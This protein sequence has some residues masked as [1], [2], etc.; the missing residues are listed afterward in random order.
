MEALAILSEYLEMHP[1]TNDADTI[2]ELIRPNSFSKQII[3]LHM[4]RISERYTKADLEL[5]LRRIAFSSSQYLSLDYQLF[6]LIAALSIP[7]VDSHRFNSNLFIL[8]T[9]TLALSKRTDPS[10]G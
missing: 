2:L 10:S 7:T 5:I 1:E 3:R 9:L 4:H 8:V 6:L